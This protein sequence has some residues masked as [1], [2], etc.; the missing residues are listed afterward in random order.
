M[1]FTYNLNLSEAQVK[2]L[3]WVEAGCPNEGRDYFGRTFLMSVRKLMR[4]GFVDHQHPQ[5]PPY[6]L[7]EKGEIVAWLMHKELADEHASF[8]ERLEVFQGT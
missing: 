2:F 6:V 7:T 3:F 8:R 5:K 1:A 4:L